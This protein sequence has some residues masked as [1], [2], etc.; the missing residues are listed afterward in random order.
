[1]TTDF[2]DVATYEHTSVTEKTPTKTLQLGA[3]QGVSWV[4]RGQT[5]VSFEECST[6]ADDFRG[7]VLRHYTG[8]RGAPVG[9]KQGWRIYEHSAHDRTLIG[10]IGLGE[11]SYKLAPRRRLGLRD[12]RPLDRT[13]SNFIYRLEGPRITPA[14]G[15]LRIW[16]PVAADC[17]ERRYG[18]R[19][20]H[21]ESMVGQGDAKVL[22]ACFRGARWRQLGWTTG[23][24]CRRQT[25]NSHGKRIWSDGPPRLVF[26]FGPLA[27]LPEPTQATDRPNITAPEIPGAQS[28]S[29]S[30]SVPC[31]SVRVVD[32]V[33]GGVK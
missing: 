14:S 31:G 7:A 4:G 5:T 25:G 3:C 23:R 20:V 1:M 18:W 32:S 33:T 13:V 27:R 16:M 9:K 12:A 6:W 28:G 2:E 10:W 29:W 17:W 24:T 15:I 22:G 26:Y 19:P 11:P 8:S 30:R 21:W